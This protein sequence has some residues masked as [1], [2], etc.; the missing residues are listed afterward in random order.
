MVKGKTKDNIVSDHIKD[1]AKTSALSLLFICIATIIVAPFTSLLIPI[2][3][4]GI[5]IS[6]VTLL[7]FWHLINYR[8][9]KVSVI[10]SFYSLYKVFRFVGDYLRF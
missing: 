2:Y 9:I 3:M 4:I 8:D 6:I 10:Y 5:I 1:S 7:T